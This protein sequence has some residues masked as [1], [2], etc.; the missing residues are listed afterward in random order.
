VRYLFP[1]KIEMASAVRDEKNQY[2]I[3]VVA[4]DLLSA[5]DEVR[6]MLGISKDRVMA[7]FVRGEIT[8]WREE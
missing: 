3:D 6:R 2:Y 8:P 7:F 5:N 1:L 4:T